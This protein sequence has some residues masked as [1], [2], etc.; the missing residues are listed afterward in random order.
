VPTI[1]VYRFGQLGDTL[2]ALPAIDAIRNEF[3]NHKMIL[4]TDAQ[5]GRD[6]HISSWS[7]LGPLKWFDDVIFYDPNK[8]G[9]S[10]MIEVLSLALKLRRLHIDKFFNL[11]PE[12]P[13]KSWLRDKRFFTMAANVRRY[14]AIPPFSSPAKIND[15][16]PIVK[17]E[18]RTIFRA[19]GDGRDS[20][21]NFCMPIPSEERAKARSIVSSEGID[22]AGQLIALAPGSKMPAKQWGADNYNELGKRLLENVPQPTLLVFGGSEDALV[23]DE[24]C[25]QWGAN[26]HNLAG[27][28]S[29]FGSAEILKNCSL[30]VGNDTGTMHLAAMVGT[31]C[32]ALFSARDY[33]GKWEPYGSQHAVIRK[34]VECEG[35]MLET[36]IFGNKCLSKIRVEETLE[37]VSRVIRVPYG[38]Q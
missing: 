38:E 34:T 12:R 16:L 9:M 25:S 37:K 19:L 29:I 24:L 21:E 32:V 4:L 26:S 2:V 7:I 23:G 1:V 6:G 11:S 20:E 17:A 10:K 35:C 28:L 13:M 36:C 31:P 22:L 18:W 33:P 8:S 3:P 30:Y 5:Q 15:K 27:K 14:S